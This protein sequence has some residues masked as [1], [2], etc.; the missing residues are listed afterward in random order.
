M[1]VAY[2]REVFEA[3]GTFDERFDAC[4]DVEFNH[5]VDRAGLKC[6]FTPRVALRY[7]PRTSLAGLVR[8]EDFA[9]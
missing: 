4:E 9:P 3:V 7:H 8:P 5:R 1:A 6:F 2:R